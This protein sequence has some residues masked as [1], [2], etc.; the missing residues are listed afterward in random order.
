MALVLSSYGD[1]VVDLSTEV[2]LPSSLYLLIGHP[3]RVTTLSVLRDVVSMG[4]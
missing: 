2:K 1:H 3:C 4:H